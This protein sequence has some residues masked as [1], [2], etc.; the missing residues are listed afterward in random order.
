MWLYRL[1]NGSRPDLDMLRSATRQEQLKNPRAA[2]ALRAGFDQIE[3]AANHLSESS[4]FPQIG[5]AEAPSSEVGAESGTVRPPGK[6]LTVA[7]AAEKIDRTPRRVRQLAADEILEA[8]P[9]RPGETWQ[10]YEQSVDEYLLS[11]SS[12]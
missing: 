4:P 7:G 6:T 10:I 3:W 2:A 9:R 12:T 8:V 5:N 1:V 11:R